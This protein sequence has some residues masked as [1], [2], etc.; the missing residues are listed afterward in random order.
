MKETTRMQ[1]DEELKNSITSMACPD[2]QAFFRFL[3]G[4]GLR[5][6]EALAMEWADVDLSAGLLRVRGVDVELPDELLETLNNSRDAGNERP[7]S[8]INEQEIFAV[9][10]QLTMQAGASFRPHGLRRSFASKALAYK[11][12][13]YSEEDV[14]GYMFGKS[15][16]NRNARRESA[17]LRYMTE[18]K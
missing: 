12:T 1:T 17:I 5:L 6:K 4:S 9:A 2:L 15:T 11:G 14:K 3:W 13:K 8:H 10:R 7:F 16:G 18:A